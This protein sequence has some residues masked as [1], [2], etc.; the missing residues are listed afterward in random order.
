MDAEELK[1]LNK[2]K[3]LVKKLARKYNEFIVSATIPLQL[4]RLI[5]PA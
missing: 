3:K 4:Q 5:G 1:D 2:D